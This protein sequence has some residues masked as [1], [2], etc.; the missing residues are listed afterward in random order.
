LGPAE[1]FSFFQD[2]K[3]LAAITPPWLD[4]RIIGECG[5]RVC[6]GAEYDYTIRWF[7]LTIP[8][9][10]RIVDYTPGVSFTDSQVRGPYRSWV[11]RHTFEE[12][13]KGTRM[14]DRVDFTLPLAALP[15]SSVI[16]GQLG[17]IFSYRERRIT[18]WVEG[19][20]RQ[21]AT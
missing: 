17:E 15:L 19:R 1:A 9:R 12:K 14:E 6:R 4:F 2:P 13:P 18:D 7:G 10:T 21:V 8:W 16:R 11:H 3:N 5:G 20:A